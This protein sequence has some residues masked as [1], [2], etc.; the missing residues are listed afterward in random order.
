MRVLTY[1]VLVACL[2]VLPLASQEGKTKPI[3]LDWKD[4]PYKGIDDDFDAKL[5]AAKK[6]YNGKLV[7]ITGP[8]RV[9]AVETGWDGYEV[10]REKIDR[11]GSFSVG[12]N[13]WFHPQMPANERM[14]A[15]TV[16]GPK[17]TRGEKEVHRSVSC[18]VSGKLLALEPQ[19]RQAAKDKAQV[20]ITGKMNNLVL[21]VE[22]IYLA[23]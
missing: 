22:S 1:A 10:A 21:T 3:E 13:G 15:L 17:E 19:L 18:L 14:G 23:K 8:I 7:V 5:A 16:Q 20:R 12:Y 11:S 9:R 2:I 6:K 4:F